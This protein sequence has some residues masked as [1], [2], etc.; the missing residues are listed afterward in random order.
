M[1]LVA[2]WACST[3]VTGGD[4]SQIERLHPKLRAAGEDPHLVFDAIKV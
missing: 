1:V 4:G 2:S 3:V